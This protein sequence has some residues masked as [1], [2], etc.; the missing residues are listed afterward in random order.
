LFL[1]TL[2]CLLIAEGEFDLDAAVMRVARK[3]AAANPHKGV[4]RGAMLT[5]V[6]ERCQAQPTKRICS[7]L[8]NVFGYVLVARKA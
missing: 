3:P 5:S 4:L 1:L 2:C 7:A 8:K 6:R